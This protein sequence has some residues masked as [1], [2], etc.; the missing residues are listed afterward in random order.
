MCNVNTP[1]VVPPASQLYP[2][3]GE[4][5]RM[6]FLFPW[7]GLFRLHDYVTVGFQCRRFCPFLDTRFAFRRFSTAVLL[8][9][10]TRGDGWAKGSPHTG[11]FTGKKVIR[12]AGRSSIGRMRWFDL[13]LPDSRP[14]V[15]ASIGID[16]RCRLQI[17]RSCQLFQRPDCP[18]LQDCL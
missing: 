7:F 11:L 14:P 15:L 4:V 12:P 8:A 10:S 17:R 3:T 13:P 1:A 2:R 6:V 9:G 16:L 18:R 5:K